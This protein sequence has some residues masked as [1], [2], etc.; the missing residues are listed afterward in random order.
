MKYT[1]EILSSSEYK[2]YPPPPKKYKTLRGAIAAFDKITKTGY[3]IPARNVLMAAQVGKHDATAVMVYD[4]NQQIVT[5]Y[6]RK[7]D[8]P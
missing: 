3:V 4:E 6:G 7:H 1:L 8:Q 5:R 2:N